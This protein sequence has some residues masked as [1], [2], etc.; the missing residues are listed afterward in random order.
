MSLRLDWCSHEAAKYAVEH[1][2]YSKCLPS[3]K[4]VRCGVWED[5]NFIGVVIFSLGATPNLCKPYGLTQ[6]QCCELTRVALN[7]HKSAVSRIL[8]I[9]IK[10][11]KRHCPGL[12]LIVSFADTNKGH[13]GGIYQANGWIFSGSARLDAWII[14]GEKFHPRS[15]VA[16]FGSQSIDRVRKHDPNA[17]KIWG[18]KHRYL[19]PLDATMRSKTLSLS[20]PYPKRAGSK[21][22]VASEFHSGG[23]GAIPTPAL[24]DETQLNESAG[25]TVSLI[26]GEDTAS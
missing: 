12:R 16:K 2:H 26:Q 9:A 15:V 19:M 3:G 8:A 25:K 5:G 24:Q 7:R 20:K 10:M 13:H 11:L 21:E 22:N 23:G 14:H 18:I 4:S 6:Q 1:W 17:K